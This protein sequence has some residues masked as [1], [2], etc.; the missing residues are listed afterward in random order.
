MVCKAKKS[1]KW[2]ISPLLPRDREVRFVSGE[3]FGFLEKRVVKIKGMLNDIA[4][5][6]V[7]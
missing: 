3:V 4:R 1:G 7:P 2:G 6:F 5:F